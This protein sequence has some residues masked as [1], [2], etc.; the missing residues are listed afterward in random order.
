MLILTSILIE[1]LLLLDY[2]IKSLIISD[3]FYNNI[4][5]TRNSTLLKK[6]YNYK[7]E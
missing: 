4:S 1:N 5:I 6:V 3:S 2:S 7:C